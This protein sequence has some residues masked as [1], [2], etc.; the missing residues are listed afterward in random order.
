MQHSLLVELTNPERSLNDTQRHII[1]ATLNFVF[2]AI[3]ELKPKLAIRALYA[4][5]GEEV[6][7]R[8]FQI[9]ISQGTLKSL[10][11]IT[12]I[13]KHPYPQNR[14]HGDGGAYWKKVL[15]GRDPIT[16]DEINSIQSGV[17]HGLVYYYKAGFG[18]E[19]LTEH[20]GLLG[21][22]A[23]NDDTSLPVTRDAVIN[24]IQYLVKKEIVTQLEKYK[25]RQ[26]KTF[27]L[28]RPRGSDGWMDAYRDGNDPIVYFNKLL[29]K[30][31]GLKAFFSYD[32]GPSRYD[33]WLVKK[34]SDFNEHF[35][36]THKNEY[37]IKINLP[38]EKVAGLL[39]MNRYEELLPHVKV[40]YKKTYGFWKAKVA[41]NGEEFIPNTTRSEYEVDKTISVGSTASISIVHEKKFK[42]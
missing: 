9:F 11:Q 29:K 31:G 2:N 5:L 1:E 7:S 15:N 38:I 26:N 33:Q 37:V 41:Y 36:K 39:L 12:S 21:L 16:Q 8:D 35:E 30:E 13:L 22:T 17:S 3:N 40:L 19:V 6:T 14:Y 24:Y 42:L 18:S 20:Q 4:I 10:Q 34:L 23:R 27:V 28:H 25:L 32:F